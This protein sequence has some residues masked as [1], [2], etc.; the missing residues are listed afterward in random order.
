MASRPRLRRVNGPPGASPTSVP[1]PEPSDRELLDAYSEA[2][3]AVV[4]RVGPAVASVSVAA[5]REGSLRGGGGSGVLFTP[6]GYLLTNAHVVRGAKR[7]GVSLTDG[8]TLEASL[9]GADEPT[10]LAVIAVD[11]SRLPYVDLGSSAALRVGQL[12]VAIGNPLGFSS[13]VSAG[14][15]SALGRTMRATSGRLMEG[16]IQSDVALNPGN[17]GGPLVDSRARVVGINTAMILGA[18]GLSFSVPIDTAKWVLGQLMTL[19]RV[20]RGYLGI[21]GQNRPLAR[22]T[23]RRLGLAE[24]AG[25]E[26]M[27]V[28][29]GGPAAEAGVAAGDIIVAADGEPTR[30]VDDLHRL[31]GRWPRE[32]PV[33]LRILRGGT[34]VSVEARP[35]EARG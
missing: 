4:E 27:R 12:V 25:V 22:G 29:R 33:A 9:V 3:I 15:V 34:L 20:R 35:R 8:S 7:V 17:S 10:D 32:G 16:I 28:E 5:R 23:A 1:A 31:L 21:A 26:V 24:D 11:G 2:V 30:S 14:V 18:Q 13:T 6:D 19:G